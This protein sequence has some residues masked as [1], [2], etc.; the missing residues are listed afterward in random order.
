M[1]R[2]SSKNIS[3]E[4]KLAMM[5]ATIAKYKENRAR[6]IIEEEESEMKK[7]MKNTTIKSLRSQAHANYIVGYSRMRKA[8]LLK[9][10]EKR[11]NN[12]I[13]LTIPK[14][15]YNHIFGFLTLQEKS[16]TTGVCKSM[17]VRT[18][19][20]YDTTEKQITKFGI[21]Y[22]NEMIEKI[23]KMQEYNGKMGRLNSDICRFFDLYITSASKMGKSIIVRLVKHYLAIC[24][25][26]ITKNIKKKVAIMIMKFISGRTSFLIAHK[27]FA[28]TVKNKMIEFDQ[29]TS[30]T[31]S[32]RYEMDKY[33]TIIEEITKDMSPEPCPHC[34]DY[35]N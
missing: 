33:K 19:Q 22:M 6:M 17:R 8:E 7:N 13:V 4:K 31:I 1:L 9:V 21:N 29:E 35:H 15:V 32:E 18:K 3:Y 10:V 12:E 23:T 2:K 27:R 11:I 30:F 34:G 25:R 24:E 5:D 16:I 28:I 14:D 26:T 20:S